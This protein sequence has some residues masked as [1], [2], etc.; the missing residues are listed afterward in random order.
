[1][2]QNIMAIEDAI[3]NLPAPGE[4]CTELIVYDP[5]EKGYKDWNNQLL[6]GKRMEPEERMNSLTWKSAAEPP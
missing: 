2:K 4:E 6:L 1:M 5:A 3:R